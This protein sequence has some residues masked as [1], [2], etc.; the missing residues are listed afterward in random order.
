MSLR[1]II[2]GEIWGSCLHIILVFSYSECFRFCLGFVTAFARIRAG[3][4]VAARVPRKGLRPVLLLYLA[5]SLTPALLLEVTEL[6]N[7][8]PRLHST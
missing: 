6:I 5:L 3:V 1:W 2:G 8:E 4:S 7:Q